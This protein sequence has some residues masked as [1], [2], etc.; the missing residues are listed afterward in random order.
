MSANSLIARVNGLQLSILISI[1]F[2]LPN[3]QKAQTAAL[4]DS[5]PKLI[6]APEFVLSEKAVAA[7]VDGTLLLLVSVAAE[8]TVKSARVFAGPEW[9]CVGKRP[10]AEIKEVIK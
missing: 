5:E 1:L 3:I 8:G 7:G 6:E 10:L 9:P 2:L 4:P